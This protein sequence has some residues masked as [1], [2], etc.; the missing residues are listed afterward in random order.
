MN[1]QAHIYEY[2]H[3]FIHRS[4]HSHL[5]RAVYTHAQLET[6]IQVHTQTHMHTQRQINQPISPHILVSCKSQ[7]NHDPVKNPDPKCNVILNPLPNLSLSQNWEK[8][9]CGPLAQL[10]QCVCPLLCKVQRVPGFIPLHITG[11][12]HP[13]PRGG[14]EHWVALS[15]L[16]L[17]SSCRLLSS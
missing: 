12:S 6:H 7:A 14:K 8:K 13:G 4:T 10:L 5:L 9:M 17:C 15:T 16:H 1:T 3:T 2:V 11:P